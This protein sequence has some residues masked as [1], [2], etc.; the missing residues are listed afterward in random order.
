ML[1][2]DGIRALKPGQIIHADITE[3]RIM[4]NLKIYIYHVVD[5]FSRFVFTCRAEL[6]RDPKIS[7]SNLES[8]INRFEHLFKERFIL[9]VDDGIENKGALKDFTS[10]N[11]K[12]V[13]LLIAQKDIQ[14]SNSMVEGANKILKHQYLQKH[15]FAI[16]HSLQDFLDRYIE[17]FNERPNGQLHGHTPREVLEGQIPDK[18]RFSDQMRETKFVRIRENMNFN[19]NSCASFE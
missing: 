3:I 10:Q 1:L 15:E 11:R 13:Q 17:D 7:L 6:V 2:T 5:N 4:N 16:I 18:Y 9:L 8:I 12:L 14:F 19:C